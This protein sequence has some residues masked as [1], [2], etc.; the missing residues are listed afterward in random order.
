MLRGPIMV[1]GS[2]CERSSR[3]NRIYHEY[4]LMREQ[5]GAER[6]RKVAAGIPRAKGRRLN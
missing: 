3:D 4:P 6:V 1:E 2:L 5:P